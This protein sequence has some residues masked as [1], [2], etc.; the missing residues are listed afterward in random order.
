MGFSPALAARQP[1][2]GQR[3]VDGALKHMGTVFVERRFADDIIEG[4]WAD[5]L[6]IGAVKDGRVGLLQRRKA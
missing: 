1:E 4:A 3:N 5:G 6:V 2:G